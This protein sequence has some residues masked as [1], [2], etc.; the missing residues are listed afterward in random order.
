MS[1]DARHASGRDSGSATFREWLIVLGPLHVNKEGSPLHCAFLD[2]RAAA[3]CDDHK[4]DAARYWHAENRYSCVWKKAERA[5]PFMPEAV[6]R[7]VWDLY[8]EFLEGAGREPHAFHDPAWR[9]S[10]KNFA[11]ARKHLED[12]LSASCS[13]A[14]SFS[15]ARYGCD[16]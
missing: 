2:L 12:V 7:S 16:L 9:E 10:F 13:E 4:G 15:R 5:L 8:L 1:Y 6:F 11:D 3:I 14:S